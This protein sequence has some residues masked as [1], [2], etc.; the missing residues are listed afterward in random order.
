MQHWQAD[1]TGRTVEQFSFDWKVETS[2]RNQRFEHLLSHEQAEKKPELKKLNLDSVKAVWSRLW[3]LKAST[4]IDTW[5][6]SQK[7]ITNHAV[8][9][10]QAYTTLHKMRLGYEAA[11]SRHRVD[12]SW[13]KEVAEAE[14]ASHTADNVLSSPSVQEMCRQRVLKQQDELL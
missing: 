10:H 4:E 11:R 9:E 3:E 8:D 6:T 5:V 7:C 13:T 2:A 14:S 1:E 12:I